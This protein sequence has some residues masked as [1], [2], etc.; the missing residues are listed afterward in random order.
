MSTHKSKN[1]FYNLVLNFK[2]KGLKFKITLAIITSILLFSAVPYF[3]GPGLTTAQ[4]MGAY[5]NGK[6]LPLS[7]ATAEPYRIAYPGLSFFYPITF[8]E[9]PSRNKIII[10]QLDGQIFSFDIDQYEETGV[11]DLLLDLSGDVGL[12]SDGGFLGLTIHPD[13]DAAT[14]PKNYIYVYYATKNAAGENSPPFGQFTT[15]NCSHFEYEGNFLMLERFEVGS[16]AMTINPNSRTIIMKNR[17]YGTGHR[18]GGLEFGDDGFL[19]LSIGDQ[20]SWSKAQDITNDIDGG[21]IRI[22]VDKD[23]TKSH[24]PIRKKPTDGFADEITGEEYWIPNDNPFLSPD[25]SNFEE[26]Y[27]VGL[28]NPHRMTKDATTGTF[29][30]GDVGLDS[31]EEINV[32]NSGG[33]NFGWPLWE[34]NDAGPGCVPQLLDNMAHEAPLVAFPATEANSITGGFVY[35][36]TEMPEY[37]GKY[38]CADFGDGDE[39]WSVNTTTGAYELIGNFTPGGIISFGQDSANEIYLLPE[40]NNTPIYKMKSA[41]ADYSLF[42]QTLSATNIFTDMT[43]LEVANGIVPYDLVESFWSDGALKRRWMAIPNDGTHNSDAEQIE[44]SENGDWIFPIGSVLIKHFDLPVDD[45]DSSITKKIETRLSI[46]GSD[47]NFYY[48]TYNWNE[49][50]TDAVLQEVGLD[51]PVT[52]ATE[53]GG[54]RTQTWHFPSNTDCKTCHNNVVSGALGLKARYLNSDYD[55]TENGTTTTANQLVTLSHL[56]ILDETIVDTDTPNILTSKSIY[57]TNATL[58]EKARSYLDLNCAYCHRPET[59]NRANFDLRLFNSLE[60]TNIL[61]AGILSPLG[62]Y[63]DEKIIYPGDSLR[64]ILYHR[65]NSIDPTVMMPT[66]SKNVIDQDAV[67]LIGLW[68]DQLEAPTDTINTADAS[69]NLALLPSANV[70]GSVNDGRGEPTDI[71]Y[72]PRINEYYHQTPFNEYGVDLNHNLGPIDI[73][74][75]FKWQVSWPIAKKINYITFGGVYP[76]QAQPNTNWKISYRLND[77][78]IMHEEGQGGW[79]NAGIYEWGSKFQTPITADAIKLEAFSDGVND[80]VS[81]HLRGRG[82][83]STYSS[84]YDDSDTNPKA[85][86]IQYLPFPTECDFESVTAGGQT[87]CSEIDTTYSQDITITYH[88]APSNGDLIVNGQAFAVTS[89]PQTVTLTGLLSDGESKDVEVSFSNET[90]CSI[91]IEDLFTAPVN[92][93]ACRFES[94]TS[95]AQSACNELNGTYTQE[96]SVTYVNE[97]ESGNLMVNGQAFPIS[98]SPQTVLLTGLASNGLDQ[99]VVVSFSEENACTLTVNNLYTAPANCNAGAPDNSPDTSINLGLLSDAILSGSVTNGR[100]A[101]LDILY[102]PALNNYRNVTNYNEYGVAYNYNLGTPTVDEGMKWQVN[103]NNAKYINYITFGG[104]YSNQPQVNTMW[105][106]SYHHNDTWTILEEGQGGWIDSGIYEW[107]GSDQQPFVADALRVQLYSDGSN[108]VIHIHLRGRG[109]TSNRSEGHDQSTTPKATLIQYIPLDNTCGANLTNDA[110]L[111]CNDTWKDNISPDGT[112][113]TKDMFIGNG[114]YTVDADE[115]IVVDNLIVYT[116]AVIVIKEGGSITVNGDL[117]NYGKIQLESISTKYSSLIVEG[118]STGNVVYKRHI[119]AYNGVT[120]NDLVSAPLS[121]QSFGDFE[122]DNPN[123]LENPNNN[124]QKAFA[125]FD[126]PNGVYVNYAITT[127]S[128]TTIENGIGFRAARDSIEDGVS[129]TTFTFT[130]QVETG[131]VSIPITETAGSSFRGWNLIGNPYPSYIDF[132]E[133]FEENKDQLN[134]NGAYQAIYGYNNNATNKWTIYN[135]LNTSE[136]IAPGQGFFIKSKSGGGTIEFLSDIRTYGTSDDFIVG[137]NSS[138]NDN[139]GYIKLQ[140]TNQDSESYDTAIHFN[141][142][143]SLGLDAGYDAAMFGGNSTEFCINSYLVNDNLG[144][145]IAIQAL[146]TDDLVSTIVPLGINAEQGQVITVSLSEFTLPITTKVYLEDN[147]TN[148]FTLLNENDYSFTALNSISGDGRFYL[149]FENETLNVSNQDF[150]TLKITTNQNDKTIEITGQLNQ[151][152][153][154]KLYDIHGRVILT[155]NLEVNTTQQTIAVSH[156][157]TGIYIVELNSVSGERRIQKLVIN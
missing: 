51:E 33:K 56:G 103:W 105:R 87:A 149:R 65:M 143:A 46:M 14:N 63:A 123:I 118:S 94:I 111:Y 21:V 82:G 19:Y 57:D 28:R 30:I 44:Y 39:M 77:T 31:N 81:I 62:N 95:G 156:L 133:F 9:I 150:N 76:N 35:R 108:S 137:R 58:D 112:T 125:P 148:T 17:M 155:Q 90:S 141:E 79:I 49:A 3:Y 101:P 151:E 61:N 37:I 146:G 147:I 29:Y 98:G 97:P 53:G 132:S 18:G 69:I 122:N 89:S 7:T 157:N 109:G 152:T 113:G 64:S 142:N 110:L 71:L 6:F 4:P 73:N 116:D 144:D 85:T 83:E 128:D 119:N 70:E 114:I 127:D 139:E 153:L 138:T 32:L 59:G 80:V 66:L 15:Q 131:D 55:Y 48:L 135:S 74:N 145:P 5:L 47:G 86:L 121:G 154:F 42:P 120:G 2:S 72:D 106:I 104:T 50:Q 26:Y 10:G 38:I 102:D 75:A 20:T 93:T 12:V 11:K 140:I 136:L 129:G 43:T 25:G 130:G 27:S 126:E 34:G 68:I 78:W 54:T 41:S 92:C 23:S 16:N 36:G 24:A 40:G 124:D 84:S 8:N 60:A 117:T 22:D 99:N 134:S 107:G 67:D 115:A 91:I 100:G 52:I 88:N 96:I 1:N 13:F 45:T